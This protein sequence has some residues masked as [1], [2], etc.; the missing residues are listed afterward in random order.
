MK[1]RQQRHGTLQHCAQPCVIGQVLQH[2]ECVF[3]HVIDSKLNKVES[4]TWP[5]LVGSD[6]SQMT[7]PLVTLSSMT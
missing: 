2:K 1:N 7:P 4:W 6:Y 3:A 5:G